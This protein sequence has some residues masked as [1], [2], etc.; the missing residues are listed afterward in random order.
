MDKRR[1]ARQSV[2]IEAVLRVDDIET[3]DCCIKDFSQGGL[4]ITLNDAS[5]S[6]QLDSL[7][8]GESTQ[9][10]VSFGDSPEIARV[11][12]TIAHVSGNGIGLRFYQENPND[13]ILL[14]KA[15]AD[16]SATSWRSI[17]EQKP[18]THKQQT[19]LIGT[20]NRLMR[21]FL[22]THLGIFF[23]RLD[24]ALLHES[25]VHKT[26]AM[27][28]TFLDALAQFRAEYTHIG[29]QVI[30]S[31]TAEALSLVNEPD[32]VETN[33]SGA[34][35]NTRS[36]LSLIEKDEFED[37]LVV[38]VSISKA[39]LHLR[40]QLLELQLRMDAGFSSVQSAE[41]SN[42]YSPWA[43]GL[44]MADAVRHMH[45]GNQALT[46]VFQVFHETVLL[47][48]ESIYRQL[49]SLL[50]KAGVLPELNISRYLASQN[51]HPTDAEPGLEQPFVPATHTPESSPLQ[52]AAASVFPLANDRPLASSSPVRR[53]KAAYS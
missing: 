25:S 22:E 51:V 16:S 20:T 47:E 38:R 35:V 9:A 8:R 40:A 5:R 37:W 46:Q 26:F 48:L 4:L 42:P 14:Q 31:V 27:R 18:L 15:A 39:E 36:T 13:L 12:V 41:V 11:R 17:Q 19:N 44:A 50:L 32:N 29:P 21:H 34:A 30:N 1:Y 33:T 52:S 6:K 23:R 3:C 43:M 49:N 45:L 53:I 24:Q 2:S 10:V 28:Q 7:P